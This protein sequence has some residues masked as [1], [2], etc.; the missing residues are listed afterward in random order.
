MSICPLPGDTGEEEEKA[1]ESSKIL[2]EQKV[3]GGGRAVFDSVS[4]QWRA[5]Q[6]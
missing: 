2:L 1:L 4:A 6:R 5:W 3:K